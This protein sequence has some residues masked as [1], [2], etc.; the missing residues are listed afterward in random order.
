MNDIPVEQ[1]SHSRMGCVFDALIVAAVRQ[2]TAI[3]VRKSAEFAESAL[4]RIKETAGS[5][6]FLTI[7]KFLK[8]FLIFPIQR[9]GKCSATLPSPYGP[10]LAMLE[11]SDTPA[12]RVQCN[13]QNDRR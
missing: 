13:C 8:S 9:A 7:W 4:L 12:R 10:R 11:Q 1:S 2:I 3:V 6:I 5:A